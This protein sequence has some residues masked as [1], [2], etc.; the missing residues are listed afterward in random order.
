[1]SPN[2][3]ETVRL[4]GVLN[5]IKGNHVEAIKYFTKVA[6]GEPNSAIAYFNLSN[7]YR[8][9]GDI[10]NAQSNLQKALKIDP[11]IINKQGQK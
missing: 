7:A 8:N 2:D 1:M 10:P 9:N 3:F 6:E 4:L 5:G 11:E